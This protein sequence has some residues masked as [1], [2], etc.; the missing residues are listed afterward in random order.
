MEKHDKGTLYVVTQFPTL[1]MQIE[2]FSLT[3]M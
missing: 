1:Y 3:L 2:N